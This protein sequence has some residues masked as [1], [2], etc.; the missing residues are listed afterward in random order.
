MIDYVPLCTYLVAGLFLFCS[1]LNAF[2]LSKKDWNILI[3]N[4]NKNSISINFYILSIIIT[5]L[6]LGYLL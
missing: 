3:T 1:E 2:Y 5:Y 4:N 6:S